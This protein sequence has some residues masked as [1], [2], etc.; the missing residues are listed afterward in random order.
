VTICGVVSVV[1][2]V[3]V[4]SPVVVV[5][6]PSP[7]VAAVSVPDT[8]ALLRVVGAVRTGAGPGALHAPLSAALDRRLGNHTTR[9]R[10][11][12]TMSTIRIGQYRRRRYRS[13]AEARLTAEMTF[14]S[15]T[16]D[17]PR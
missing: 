6:V 14:L 16:A 3:G 5:G 12:S 13:G 17:G 8:A 7:V 10:T 15:M 4:P 2:V 1:V 9:P 11:S